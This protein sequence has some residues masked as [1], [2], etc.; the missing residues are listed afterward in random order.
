MYFENHAHSVKEYL[1]HRFRN[2]LAQEYKIPASDNFQPFMD[3]I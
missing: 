1:S 3:A 2:Q